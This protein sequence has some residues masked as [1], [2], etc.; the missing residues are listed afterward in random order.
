MGSEDY[1]WLLAHEIGYLFGLSYRPAGLMKPNSPGS[2]LSDGEVFMAHF[3][4]GSVLNWLFDLHPQA[5]RR[6]CFSFRDGADCLPV[7]YDLPEG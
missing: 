1:P 3:K 5:M 7:A 4:E 6:P 2:H